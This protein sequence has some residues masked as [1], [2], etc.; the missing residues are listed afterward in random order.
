MKNILPTALAL[1]L[2]LL[3]TRHR[4]RQ[5]PAQRCDRRFKRG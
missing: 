4:R 1:A 3:L 2:S 5:R